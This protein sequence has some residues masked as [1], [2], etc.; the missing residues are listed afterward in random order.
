MANKEKLQELTTTINQNSASIIE[1]KDDMGSIKGEIGSLQTFVADLDS[2][3][4]SIFDLLSTIQQQGSH[5]TPDPQSSGAPP[6][7]QGGGFD[8]IN[9]LIKNFRHPA[10]SKFTRTPKVD[11]PRFN[12]TNPHGWV[13]KCERYFHLHNFPEEE[14]VDMAA[15]HFDSQVDPWYLNYQQGKQSIT[16]ATFVQGLY[17]RFEDVAHDN[18]VIS[19]NKL[20]QTS[21]VEDYYD[22]WEHYKSYMV[23]NN[24]NPARPEN[25]YTL[26]FISGLKEEIRTVVQMFKPADTSTTFYLARLQQASVY[27]QPKPIKSFARPFTPTLLS[28]SHP[29][30]TIKPFFSSTSTFSKG[31]G[32]SP[33]PI[34]THPLT[35]TKHSPDSTLPP[36]KRLT[37]AQ[38]QQ[39]DVSTEEVIDASHSGGEFPIEIS[40]HALTGATT[41]ETIRISGHLN[42]HTVTVL[43]DTCSTHSF[44]DATLIS[45]LGLH[46]SPTGH[47][48]VTV[49]NGDSTISQ[50]ICHNLTWEMQGYQFSANLRSLPLGGCDIVL[51]ADWIRQLGDVLFNFALLRISFL[52][53]GS[54]ITLQGTHS[55]PS[56]SLISGSSFVKYL[57]QN[58]PTIIGQFFSIS[59]TPIIPP[60]PAVSTLLDTFA[61]VFAEPTGLPPSRPLDHKIPLKTGSNPTSQRP[62]KCPYIH[63]F[64]VE[65][66]V[67]EMLSNGVIQ[68]SH[69]PF[70]APILLVK[71]KDD[72]WRFCVDYHKLNDITVK[73][74]F[75]IPLIKELLDELNRSVVFS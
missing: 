54:T 53:Q 65:S 50:D 71:N 26:S 74:K 7:P 18:Y 6:P 56:L 37:H 39:G 57:K 28:V 31:T 19:F 66:L 33:P 69:S 36:M 1:I 46:V 24:P 41:H 4:S 13:L 2:K 5:R 72:T 64:V 73:D 43:I 35:P 14:R 61:D 62:Y 3:L 23:T 8:D 12:G 11:F 75:P 20:Y 55:K 44:I 10:P 27:P 52:H 63:K 40:L 70:A 17:A 21:T 49:A 67:S 68:K 42:K 51:E 25:F 22:K 9:R 47:M 16:W 15:I 29:P 60:L 45:Q 48:L 58:T 38:M 30:S 59:S 34:L 32:T